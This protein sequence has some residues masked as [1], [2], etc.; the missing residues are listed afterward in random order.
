MIV[1]WREG[2]TLQR[3][4]ARWWGD[5]TLWPVLRDD[6]GLATDPPVAGRQLVLRDLPSQDQLHTVMTGD[7]WE[8]ISLLYY[9]TEHFSERLRQANDTGSHIYE[10]V[11][12]RIFVRAIVDAGT[13][14]RLRRAAYAV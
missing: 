1:V 5:W 9:G 12:E 4:A 10:R 7:S 2:D 11:G 6:N 13:V 3:I 8:S 14:R